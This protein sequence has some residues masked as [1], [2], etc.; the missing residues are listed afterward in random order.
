MLEVGC[1]SGVFSVEVAR[2]LPALELHRKLPA[3]VIPM[4]YGRDVDWARNLVKARAGEVVQLGR[5]FTLAL[6]SPISWCRFRAGA[7]TPLCVPFRIEARAD[8]S[9]G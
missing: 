9:Q 4:T 7:A 3:T 8:D 2:H 5:R 6:P 1:G